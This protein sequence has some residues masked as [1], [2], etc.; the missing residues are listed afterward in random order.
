MKLY[1]QDPCGMFGNFYSLGYSCSIATPGRGDLKKVSYILGYPP[2]GSK[3]VSYPPQAPSKLVKGGGGGG[4]KKCNLLPGTCLLTFFQPPPW[5]G[6]QIEGSGG[7]SGKCNL[8]PG[9]PEL[10]FLLLPPPRVRW[11]IEDTPITKKLFAGGS[12]LMKYFL[13]K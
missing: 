1:E 2:R 4:Q 7:G 6:R 9:R 13:N 5:G 12:H 11:Q 8:G 10:T 3:N